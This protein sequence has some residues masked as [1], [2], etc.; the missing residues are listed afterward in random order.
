MTLC[1][2]GC[3]IPITGLDVKGYRKRFVHGHN[4][5]TRDVKS[6]GYRALYRPDHP[7]A[8]SHGRIMEHVLIAE[9]AL[10][11]RLPANAEVHHVDDDS[12]N[13][14]RRNLVICQDKAYH[15]LLHRR[16]KIVRAGGNPNTEK[17]CEGCNRMLAFEHFHKNSRNEETGR[18]PRCRG[19]MNLYA[20]TRAAEARA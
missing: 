8:D 20:R 18:A 4:S 7:S 14:L 11:H 12:L 16:A 1:E 15:A 17:R 3:G 6:G 10:G 2:C 19:C 9:N 13:N 5:R